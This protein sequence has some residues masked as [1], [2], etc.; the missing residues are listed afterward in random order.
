MLDLNNDLNKDEGMLVS[1]PD[2]TK[3]SL[4]QIREFQ[5]KM[6]FGAENM[7]TNA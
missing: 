1:L 7:A 5:E 4:T 3:I 6:K 2:G